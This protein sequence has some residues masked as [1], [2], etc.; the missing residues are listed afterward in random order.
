MDDKMFE[1]RNR[2]LLIINPRAGK[3]KTRSQL[4][5]ITDELSVGGREI[6]VYTTKCRGDAT[7]LA[8]DLSPR[9]DTII[10]RGGDGTLNEVI[11]G[12]MTIEKEKRPPVGYVPSG[13]TNDFARS[14]NISSNPKKCVNHL[15]RGREIPHDIGLFND[16]KYF[17]YISCFGAFTDLTY[18]TS[19]F[20]K[21]I[22]GHAAYSSQI[23]AA[24]RRLK[25]I[26]TKVTF[27]DNEVI[28]DDL[29]YGAVSNALSFANILKMDK[30][31]V[32]FDDGKFEVTLVKYPSNA[33]DF[34]NTCKD[35]VT[36]KGH[37]NPKYVYFR[38]AKKI[39][40]E[41]KEDV[42]WTL[43]GEYGGKGKIATVEAL[44]QAVNFI[45]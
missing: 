30:N 11:N 5:N 42:S 3:M 32:D 13:S 29:V 1:N 34:L 20:A 24:F 40:F 23:L 26:N 7:R 19:Q 31:I 41:F 43:D 16:E 17:T 21:N 35:M 45:R 25:H 8:R 33:T 36:G 4:L 38:Q 39:K 37:Y 2:T 15:V 6:T 12:V 44:H 9:Y 14:L 18:N 10:C 22:F 28:E 27:D